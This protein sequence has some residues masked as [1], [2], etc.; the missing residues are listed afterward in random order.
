MSYT[1][2][3]LQVFIVL[4]VNDFILHEKDQCLYDALKTV[5]ETLEAN[6]VKSLCQSPNVLWTLSLGNNIGNA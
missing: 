5:K 1:L 2:F 3:F 6:M 4:G